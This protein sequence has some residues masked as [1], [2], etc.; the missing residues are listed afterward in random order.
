MEVQEAHHQQA[1]TAA[2]V[3]TRSLASEERSEEW[4]RHRCEVR[5]RRKQ[6]QDPKYGAAMDSTAAHRQRHAAAFSLCT[7]SA[8]AASN[9]LSCIRGGTGDHCKQHTQLH[10]ERP[11]C[12]LERGEFTGATATSAVFFRDLPGSLPGRWRPSN[13]PGR[14]LHRQKR[15]SHHARK[16]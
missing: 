2:A 6:R 5:H 16:I 12:Q 9:T 7:L 4:E 14:C 10:L 3:L 1:A 15:P 11:S 8:A 13:V